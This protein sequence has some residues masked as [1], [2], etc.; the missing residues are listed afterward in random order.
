MVEPTATEESLRP[1]D[2]TNLKE[3]ITEALAATVE[4][5]C[6][7][8]GAVVANGDGTIVE[9][10]RNGCIAASKRG[11]SIVGDCTKHAEVELLR[12]VTTT[13]PAPDRASLTLYTS[14]EPCVMC[15]GAIYWSGITRIVYGCSASQLENEVSGP[16]GF[17]IDIRKL[18]TLGTTQKPF[19][20][21]GPL[22]SDE[23]LQCHI[24]SGVWNYYKNKQQE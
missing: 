22:L 10:G 13:I 7:P 23:A 5:G 9:R 12:K 6:M 24:T 14:T 16:G 3:S 15:A 20:I 1:Y 19:N 21:I 8:F 2:V 18:Y 11:G 4:D 17:D